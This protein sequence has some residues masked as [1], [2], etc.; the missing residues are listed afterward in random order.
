VAVV[1]GL[2]DGHLAVCDRR[3]IELIAADLPR[4]AYHAVADLP[5]DEAEAL[6]AAVDLSIAERSDQALQAIGDAVGDHALVAVGVVGS[7]R[8]I[9]GVAT[10]LASHALM[11]AAEGEQYRRGM[12]AA[13]AE[14][15]LRALRTDPRQLVAEVA[16]TLGWSPERLADECAQV[17]ATLG[18]PWQKDHKDAAAAALVALHA[19]D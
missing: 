11:H 8:E 5:P 15:G 18:P 10:V 4:Q 14:L 12:A 13:A 16:D 7:S 6:V 9:P 2:V 3:R 1:A 17:R 19:V